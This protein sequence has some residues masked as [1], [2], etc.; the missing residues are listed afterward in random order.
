M[1]QLFRN[2]QQPYL[3]RIISKL[4]V[5]GESN[6]RF[7]VFSSINQ[8]ATKIAVIGATVVV[9]GKGLSVQVR[10]VQQ[11]DKKKLI[12]S[13]LINLQI[14]ALVIIASLFFI[15]Q[16]SIHEQFMNKQECQMTEWFN[17]T[18]SDQL[19]QSITKLNIIYWIESIL[20]TINQQKYQDFKIL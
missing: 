15:S 14:V 4:N 13:T 9:Y 7:M 3:Y 8:I 5:A 6:I 20:K 11:L 17:Y 2:T 12:F 16:T 18:F 19:I 10:N 1:A